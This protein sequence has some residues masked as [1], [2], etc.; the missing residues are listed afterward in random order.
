MSLNVSISFSSKS[1]GR[2]SILP[3][4][5]ETDC[6]RNEGNE[7]TMSKNEPQNETTVVGQKD[8]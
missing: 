1:L 3:I 6:N 5:H 2:K 7:R 8:P 4:P